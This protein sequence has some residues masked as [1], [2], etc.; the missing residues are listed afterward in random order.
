MA[1]AIMLR[2]I[3]SITQ[4]TI[5]TITVRRRSQYFIVYLFAFQ[6]HISRGSAK[7]ARWFHYPE[8]RVR[9]STAQPYAG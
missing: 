9:V 4:Y 7:A 5:L 2:L 6:S 8:L 3:L 1:T